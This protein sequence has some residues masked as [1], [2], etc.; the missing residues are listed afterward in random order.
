MRDMAVVDEAEVGPGGR[1]KRY[2]EY[3][4]SGLEGL[5]EIPAHW[6]LRRLKTFADVRVSNVD[7]KSAEG[8]DQV[9]LCN[10]TDVYYNERITSALAFMSATATHDQI[11]RFALR[12]G[13]VLITKDSESWTDIAVPAYVAEDLPNVLCGYHLAHVRPGRESD[14]AYLARS[15]AAVGLRDQ[16]HVSANGI[17]RFGLSN[18]AIRT[19]LF[20]HPPIEEQAAIVAFLDRETARVDRLAGSGVRLAE[21]LGLVGKQV[22]LLREYRAAL[23][24]AA[25]TGAID[26]RDEVAA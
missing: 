16:L 20:L 6:S 11:R 7:K 1:W 4:G 21:P 22:A 9:S 13:D 19:V 25:V 8:Q 23:I 18:D 12:R 2:P 14:G 24:T 3:R 5:G 26:V 10:Y 15:F 17:T